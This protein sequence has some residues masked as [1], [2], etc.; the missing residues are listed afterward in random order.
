M[1]VRYIGK[2]EPMGCTCGKVYNVLSI[3]EGMYRIIDDDPNT[4]EDELPGYLYAPAE[5]ED[6]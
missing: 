3:E 4:D 5:F 2:T 1:K 6:V